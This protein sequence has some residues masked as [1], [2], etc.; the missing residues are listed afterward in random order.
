MNRPNSFNAMNYELGEELIQVIEL[1]RE[2]ETIRAVILTGAGTAFSSGADLKEFQQF[3]GTPH[4]VNHLRELTKVLNRIVMD[5]RLL[6]KPVIASINGPLGGGGFILA[7][8]CDLR[9]AA[10]TSK[11]KLSYTSI[12]LS[13]DGAFSLLAGAIGGLGKLSELVFLDPQLDA[14]QAL[15][16]GLLHK[17]V[18]SGELSATALKWAEQMATG[19]TKAYARTKA[20]INEAMLSNL[21]KMLELERQTIMASAQTSDYVEG[22]TA[23]FEKRAPLFQGK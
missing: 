21:E 19:A 22:I 16:Y 18:S 3:I 6:P 12:G 7:L 5:I 14:H 9:L 20:M 23:F 13:P 11:F 2:D 8:A 4:Q 17:V 1:C 10:D 15:E